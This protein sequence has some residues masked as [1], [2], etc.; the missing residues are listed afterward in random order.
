MFNFNQCGQHGT[1]VNEVLPHIG[2]IADDITIVKSIH[3]EAINHDP[4]ITYINTGVQQPGKPSLGAWLSYSLGNLMTICPL[5][6]L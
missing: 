6:W 5:T 2:S 4:A 1:W 3:T